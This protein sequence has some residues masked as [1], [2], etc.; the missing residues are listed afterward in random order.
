MGPDDSVDPIVPLA[1]LGKLHEVLESYIG[2]PATEASL[3]VR[4]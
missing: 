1:F 2:G 4:F 3:K